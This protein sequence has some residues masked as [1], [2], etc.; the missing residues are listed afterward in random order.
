MELN[1]KDIDRQSP[2]RRKLTLLYQDRI[3]RI[4]RFWESL[5]RSF[6]GGLLAWRQTCK[7]QHIVGGKICLNRRK[8][9]CRC[10]YFNQQLK[11]TINNYQIVTARKRDILTKTFDWFIILLL[12]ILLHVFMCG[13][14]VLVCAHGGGQKTVSGGSLQ[15]YPS[16]GNGLEFTSWLWWLASKLQGFHLLVLG[17]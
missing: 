6:I 3:V 15:L 10:K 7:S 13:V 4:S 9:G 8:A 16:F 17:L 2:G 11:L 12:L 14:H 5:G 1:K